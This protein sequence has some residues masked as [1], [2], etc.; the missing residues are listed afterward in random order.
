MRNLVVILMKAAGGTLIF[1][2]MLF[3]F[4]EA[5]ENL[6]SVARSVRN[7]R[8]ESVDAVSHFDPVR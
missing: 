6:F 8:G 1:G 5:F 2:V 7:A 4:S 3:F